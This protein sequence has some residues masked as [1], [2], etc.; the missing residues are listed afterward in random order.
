MS[1]ILSVYLICLWKCDTYKSSRVSDGDS[2][3]SSDSSDNSKISDSSN[4]WESYD[5]TYISDSSDSS[6]SYDS[7][8]KKWCKNLVTKIIVT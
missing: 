3:N 7:G 1:V 6:D 8:N 4:S 5:S 2:S